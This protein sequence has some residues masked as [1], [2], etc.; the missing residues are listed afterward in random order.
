MRP[1]DADLLVKHINKQ[2][3]KTD[4]DLTIAVLEV[5]RDDIIGKMPTV[6]VRK[7]GVEDG[8]R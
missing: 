7:G 1:I 3:E 5:F 4:S 2:I 8:K 6:E